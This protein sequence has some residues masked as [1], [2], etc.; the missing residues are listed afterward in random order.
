[1]IHRNCGEYTY[2]N[3]VEHLNNFT[4]SVVTLYEDEWLNM[5]LFQLSPSIRQVIIFKSSIV[6]LDILCFDMNHSQYGQWY[7]ISGYCIG[8]CV[9]LHF[10]SM[11]PMDNQEHNSIVNVPHENVSLFKGNSFKNCCVDVKYTNF[12]WSKSDQP[13]CYFDDIKLNFCDNDLNLSKSNFVNFIALKVS[14]IS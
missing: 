3:L 9:K 6:V 13:K 14:D 11:N 5:R 12:D 1:M 7:D 8:S 4:E 10:M 2:D